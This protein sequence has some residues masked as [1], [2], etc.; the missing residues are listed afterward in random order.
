MEDR[1][2]A[3]AVAAVVVTY[4]RLALL[5]QCIGKL[6]SQT[7]PCA[8]LVV[9]NDSTDGTDA[10]LSRQPDV[11]TRNTGA[12]LGGAGG[13]Q[14][15]LRWAVEAGYERV[16]LMD[17]DC[18]PEPESLERLMDADRL[19]AGQYGWLSS[20]ALWIDGSSCVMNRQLL[21]KRYVTNPGLLS[22]GLLQAKQASFVSLLVRAETVRRLGLPIGAFFIWGDDAEYTRR[23]ARESGYPCFVAG[24]SRVVH[25]MHSN[26]G[27]SLAREGLDRVDRYWYLYRNN[28]YL[29]RQE[30]PKGVAYYLFDCLRELLRV[31]LKAPEGKGKRCGII[32]RGMWAGLLFHPQIDYCKEK[33]EA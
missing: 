15:G 28:A 11:R 24:E 33:I 23:L 32:L 1:T 2:E 30:G 31:L 14:F 22:H 18:F 29:Y 13:F 19:L 25:A 10:W 26:T 3:R 9:D 8:I 17:D 5:R 27:V 4:N 12:N 16:W 6:R 20:A 21:E 7:F